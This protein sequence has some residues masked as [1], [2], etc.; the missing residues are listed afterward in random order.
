MLE[1]GRRVWY[2]KKTKER[3][4]VSMWEGKRKA[5]TFSYDD[6][7]EQDKRLVELF[8]RY[9]VKGTFN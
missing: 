3:R 2:H 5:V 9:Q 8:A 4:A 1:K 6:G 7:V